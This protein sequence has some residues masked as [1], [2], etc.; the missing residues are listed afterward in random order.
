MFKFLNLSLKKLNL[1]SKF[2]IIVSGLLL[3][4]HL[5]HNFSLARLFENRYFVSIVTDKDVDDLK[6]TYW[7]EMENAKNVHIELRD[8]KI[9]SDKF[10]ELFEALSKTKKDEMHLD[11]SNTKMDDTAIEALSKCMSNWEL[12]NLSLH[13]SNIKLSDSQFENVFK[14]LE[15]MKSLKMLHL[16]LENVNMNNK[17]RQ[18]IENVINTLPNLTHVSI[19]L[20]NNN[21]SEVD[22]VEISKLL[23]RFDVRHFFF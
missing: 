2:P 21:M 19:N 5:K 10:K 4:N 6:K 1:R 20:R 22:A 18:R 3:N 14:T 23:D 11:L 13:M 7:N 16:E 17:K 8:N 15:N 12:K 9:N